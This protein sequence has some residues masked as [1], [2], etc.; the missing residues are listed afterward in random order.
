MANT[1]RC[2]ECA[3][4]KVAHYG[5]NPSIAECFLGKRVANARRV[6]KEYQPKK[7]RK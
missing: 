5:K 1:I 6:C 2:S 3:R 7:V 4:A